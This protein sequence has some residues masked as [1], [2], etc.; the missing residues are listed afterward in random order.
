MSRLVCSLTLF[1]S[2]RGI[3]P[4]AAAKL[5]GELTAIDAVSLRSTDSMTTASSNI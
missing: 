1:I 5:A 2:D 4:A 3:A